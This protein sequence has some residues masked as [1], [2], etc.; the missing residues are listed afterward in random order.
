MIVPMKNNIVTN[1]LV[2]MI[3]GEAGFGIQSAGHFFALACSRGG[4]QIFGN[5]EYPSLIRGGHNSTSIRVADFFVG[6][7]KEILNLL[8][9]MNKETL[10][11]HVKELV[12][13]GGVVYD[14][15]VVKDYKFPESISVY[16]VPLKKLAMEFGKGDITRNTVGIS[17]L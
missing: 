16:H 11:L 17:Q 4:L 5:A 2:W 15:E 1:D 6:V 8:V 12:E 10:D 7:H 3:G 14:A 9:A 13:G